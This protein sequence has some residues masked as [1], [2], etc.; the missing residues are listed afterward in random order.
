M[1]MGFVLAVAFC[2]FCADQ[3][4]KW[5]VLYAMDLTTLQAIDVLPPFLNLRMGWN[6]GIN[7]GLLA[8]DA[9]GLRWGLVAFAVVVC[10]WLVVWA[11]TFTHPR[12]R[13]SAGLIV[14]G[15]LSNALDRVVYGAVADFLN[16]SLPGVHN[17][18][19][20]NPADVFIFVGA[21][22]LIA[23]TGGAQGHGSYG[24]ARRDRAHHDRA[25][26]GR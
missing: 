8:D 1:A 16:M 13:L 24:R 5:V 14:G 26:N 4:L 21:L 9:A 15:A 6:T 10:V 22:G 19:T 25:R 23:D 11:R 3:A 2:A 20:F 7:F 17:P 18:F 12:A